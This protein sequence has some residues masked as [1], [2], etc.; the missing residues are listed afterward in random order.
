MRAV[1]DRAVWR[2]S[3][4]PRCG[5]GC[6]ARGP[7]RCSRRRSAEY[8]RGARVVVA[9]ACSLRSISPCS[10]DRC[11]GRR[12]RLAETLARWVHRTS[13]APL[14]QTRD[15]RCA[16]AR[17]PP[18]DYRDELRLCLQQA[19]LQERD[20]LPQPGT[21]SQSQGQNTKPG[22]RAGRKV[23]GAA[24]RA[25]WSRPDRSSATCAAGRPE[26]AQPACNKEAADPKGWGPQWGSA[27]AGF[28]SV[29]RWSGRAQQRDPALARAPAAAQPASSMASTSLSTSSSAK[30]QSAKAAPAIE[31]RANS[32]LAAGVGP[33]RGTHA[34][35]MKLDPLPIEPAPA[36]A[37][38]QF[39]QPG[40]VVF[41][42]VDLNA[43]LISSS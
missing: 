43:R 32:V 12:E 19:L 33:G 3:S 2:L 7:G 20:S 37:L 4:A 11:A 25:P 23:G 29:I 13:R 40:L 38:A 8:R 28:N 39:R 21:V 30:P 24:R 18:M 1:E 17:V 35:S 9:L 10:L 36:Q 22:Q 27:A 5:C 16:G 42:H 15:G 6:R 14:R 34:P 31:T 26:K 41:Y